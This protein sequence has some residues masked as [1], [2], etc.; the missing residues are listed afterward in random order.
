M[1]SKILR[2]AI[3]IDPIDDWANELIFDCETVNLLR[4]DDKLLE[5]WLK[6]RSIDDLVESLKKIIGRGVIIGVGGLDGSFIRMI[7][8]DINLLN[9]IGSRDKYVEGEIEVE[10]SELKALHEI[11]RSSSR[12]NID[13]VNK[14]VKMILRE[15]I[16]ISK[17]FDNKIRLLKPEKIPP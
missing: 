3:Y 4:R 9:E 14:R 15:K 6:C 7:P 12:V 16:S 5:L 8:G 10:F 2:L 17:L 11:I 1:N 13:L